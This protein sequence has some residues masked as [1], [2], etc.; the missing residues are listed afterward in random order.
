MID[1]EPAT[2][3]T[4]ASPEDDFPDQFAFEASSSG[5]ASAAEDTA[6]ESDGEALGGA[7]GG[8]GGGDSRGDDASGAAT[9][10]PTLTGVKSGLRPVW[11]DYR[12]QLAR[13]LRADR[14]YARCAK[15]SWWWWWWWCLL[16]NFVCLP[17]A[18]ATPK[19]T[20]L[21]FVVG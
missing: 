18:S 19:S 9:N 16:V 14:P 10:Q 1:S 2:C 3:A 7:D 15:M 13:K 8:G 17:A 11:V 4:V 20:C 12:V 5:G 21:S 6:D